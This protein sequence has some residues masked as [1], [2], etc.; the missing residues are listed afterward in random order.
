MVVINLFLMLCDL[1]KVV[2]N[3]CPTLYIY[4]SLGG[5]ELTGDVVGLVNEGVR[6]HCGESCDIQFE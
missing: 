2:R 3:L 1:Q 6:K 5:K 4:M